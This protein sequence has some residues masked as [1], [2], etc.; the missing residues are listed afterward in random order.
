MTD[1]K[2][3]RGWT[4]GASPSPESLAFSFWF[5]TLVCYWF[6]H[7]FQQVGVVLHLF[8]SDLAGLWIQTS[9]LTEFLVFVPFK[10]TEPISLRLII[11][12]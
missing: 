6:V 8:S 5:D 7:I 1:P 3:R 4:V 11:Y 12:L 9:V 10:N 2:E